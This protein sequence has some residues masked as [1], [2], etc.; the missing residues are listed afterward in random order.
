MGLGFSS[1][2]AADDEYPTI[3]DNL[4]EQGF[5]D[6]RVF[7][8]YLVSAPPESLSLIPGIMTGN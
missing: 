4:V 6:T 5:I 8:L 1:N 3:I 7:S 2:V